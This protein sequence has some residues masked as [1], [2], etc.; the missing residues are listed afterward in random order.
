MYRHQWI[1][2][3]IK[4]QLITRHLENFGTRIQGLRQLSE[5]RN[6]SLKLK[7]YNEIYVTSTSSFKY[8]MKATSNLVHNTNT[9]RQCIGLFGDYLVLNKNNYIASYSNQEC[10]STN[11]IMELENIAQATLSPASCYWT[12]LID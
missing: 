3:C 2:Y 7:R 11:N 9:T 4:F 12:L 1:F 5:L 8:S 10:Q 6:L